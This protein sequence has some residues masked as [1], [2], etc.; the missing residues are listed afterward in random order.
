MIIRFRLS[1]LHAVLLS[2]AL[3]NPPMVTLDLSGN[4]G[5]LGKRLNVGEQSWKIQAEA[6][7]NEDL[8]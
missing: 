8:S 2:V 4:L 7:T 3:V 1:E 5:R 6:F